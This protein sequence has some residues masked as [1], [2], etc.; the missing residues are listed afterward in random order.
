MNVSSYNFICSYTPV[1]LTYFPFPVFSFPIALQ[2]IARLIEHGNDRIDL[3][4]MTHVFF[5]FSLNLRHLFAG[6]RYFMHLHLPPFL[7]LSNK[8]EKCL[9]IRFVCPSVCP[10]SNSRKY[11]SGFLKLIYVIHI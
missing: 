5:Y 6:Y 10:R 3:L 7:T 4:K 9:C 8:V 2:T 11:S 1:R